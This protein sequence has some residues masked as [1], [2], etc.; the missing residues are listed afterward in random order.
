MKSAITEKEYGNFIGGK[1]VKSQSGQTLKSINPA[2]KQIIAEFQRSNADDINVAVKEAQKA[3]EGPWINTTFTDRAAYLFKIQKIIEENKDQLS[4]VE[5]LDNGKPLNETTN[6]DIPLAA[7][8]FNYFGSVA[9]T[10][11][12]NHIDLPGMHSKNTSE[13]LGVVGM[14]IPW[15]FPLLMFA[16]K[17]APALAAGNTIV[18]KPAEQTSLAAL[19]LMKLISDVLPPGVL[20]VVTG[21]GHEAGDALASHTDIRKLAF[22]GSTEIGRLVAVKAAQNSIPC[23]TELGGKSPLLIFPDA[24]LD[25][26]AK[27]AVSAA[28]FN[29]GEVCTCGSRL[30]VHEDI[31]DELSSRIVKLMKE[32]KVGDP[33]NPETQM[34]AVASEEQFNKIHGFIKHAKENPE[35]EILCGLEEVSQDGYFIRPMLVLTDNK[36]MLAK[37][38]IFGPVLSLITFKDEA[39]AIEIAN[40]TMYGLGGG[41]ITKDEARIERITGKHGI[42]AGRIWVNMY[43]AYPAHAPF[44]GYKESG[45]GRETHLGMISA[46]T[47]NK[48]VLIQR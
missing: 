9:R 8:H 32:I 17:V 22:T 36:S 47:Q 27:I 39:E 13:P 3:F 2:T 25:E 14:I 15:N 42:K 35:L 29:Q 40:D 1:W 11:Q 20:N 31:R 5:A 28:T 24:D 10:F 30:L 7:D 33:L 43:H 18:I 26:A 21:L 46:Y 41:L 12:D 45:I 37:E 38:E 34:G 44:G 48:N 23:T 4:L 16:W 19:E 6:A